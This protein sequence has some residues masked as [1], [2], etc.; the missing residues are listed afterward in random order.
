MPKC[1]VSSGP[2]RKE[3]GRFGFI[4]SSTLGGAR[5]A[6]KGADQVGILDAGSA[7]HARGY[8]DAAG[9]GDTHGLRDIA[10]IEAP[11]NHEGNFEVEI[12]QHMPV[13]GG[14]E[15]AGAGGM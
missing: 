6:N 11:R 1:P 7:F 15:A 12:F 9:V 8:I 14:T 5:G 3:L 2:E 10:G 13:E 4:R